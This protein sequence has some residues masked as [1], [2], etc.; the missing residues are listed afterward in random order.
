MYFLQILRD[1]YFHTILMIKEK[2]MLIF[3]RFYYEIFDGFSIY[4]TERDMK[5]FEFSLF[6]FGNVTVESTLSFAFTNFP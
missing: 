4:L 6:I 5:R 3:T 1:I 2:L